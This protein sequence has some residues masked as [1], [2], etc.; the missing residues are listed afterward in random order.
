MQSSA[1]ALRCGSSAIAA[2][3]PAAPSS[4]E[5]VEEG[6][7][8]DSS[9]S[10]QRSPDVRLPAEA[11]AGQALAG[12]KRKFDAQGEKQFVF[13]PLS[14]GHLTSFYSCIEFNRDITLRRLFC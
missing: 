1:G 13:R 5:A 9:S 12:A 7:H 14:H 4:A 6:L 8:P 11:A 3:Q 10:A 2:A